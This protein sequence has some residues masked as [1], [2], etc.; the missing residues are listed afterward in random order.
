MMELAPLDVVSARYVL[1]R[2][3]KI[4]REFFADR[5]QLLVEVADADGGCVIKKD[6]TPLAVLV[7]K[8]NPIH[9]DMLHTWACMTD[10]A[11]GHAKGLL[12]LTRQGIESECKRLGAK[13]CITFCR[14]DLPDQDKW[15]R[16]VGFKP[17]PEGNHK[18]NGHTMK[19]YCYGIRRQDQKGV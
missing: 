10:A 7:G 12:R 6:G 3:R 11:R 1:H 19:G 16:A 17:A 4:D 2:M 13:L 8:R 15:V 14:E 5:R 9:E 18:V